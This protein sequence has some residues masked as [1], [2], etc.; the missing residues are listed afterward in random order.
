[1]GEAI[2]KGCKRVDLFRNMCSC[3]KMEKLD[4]KKLFQK[5]GGSKGE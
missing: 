3:M 1:M 2:R 4:I 5:L